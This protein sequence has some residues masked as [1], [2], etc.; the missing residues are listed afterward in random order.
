MPTSK[1][2]LERVLEYA[3]N[4]PLR[5][6]QLGM[7]TKKGLLRVPIEKIYMKGAVL[8]VQSLPMREEF[9]V[10]QVDALVDGELAFYA[11]MH[12]EFRKGDVVTLTYELA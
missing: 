10:T 11:V 3:M 6:T 12:R 5:P 9:S 8:Y 7:H 4:G 1:P 2:Y